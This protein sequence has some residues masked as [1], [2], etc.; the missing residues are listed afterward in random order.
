MKSPPSKHKHRDMHIDVLRAMAILWMIVMHINPS[1]PQY[2]WANFIWNIGQWVVPA[3]ILC[4]IAVDRENV[5]SFKGYVSYLIKRLKR[6]LVPYYL[7]L[8]SYLFLTV[9]LGGKVLTFSYVWKNILL[10]GGSNYNWLIFLFVIVT[11]AVPVLR[12]IAHKSEVWSV[13]FY[14]VAASVSVIFVQNR[15]YFNANYRWWMIIPWW[16]ITL[17]VI[18]LL[19]WWKKKRYANIAA[20]FITSLSVYWYWYLYFLRNGASTHTF[21][22]KYPPDIYFFN[23][24]IWSVIVAF[25]LTFFLARRLNPSGYISRFLTFTSKFSYTIFFVHILV[26]YV[27]GLQFNGKNTSY[28]AY[29]ALIFIPTYVITWIMP[30]A[31][32]LVASAARQIISRQS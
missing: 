30:R 25:V 6:L 26:L 24:G 11:V 22:H 27:V 16:G 19:Q 9:V 28:L 29:S 21:P 31:K 8:I 2:A 5:Q 4:S 3:F 20:L 7:W 1:F 32:V 14:F 17:A 15:S 13:L 23:F 18:L 12:F 10:V